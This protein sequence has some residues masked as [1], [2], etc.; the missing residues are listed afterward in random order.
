MGR[1]RLDF[2]EAVAVV[3]ASPLG[4]CSTSSS[5][6]PFQPLAELGKP[7]GS[8]ERV[9][10]MGLAQLTN[11]QCSTYSESGAKVH[12]LETLTALFCKAPAL[13][14]S[15]GDRCILDLPH[16]KCR[17]TGSHARALT[18]DSCRGVQL[19]EATHFSTGALWR[20]RTP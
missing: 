4:S 20:S 14:H 5:A 1:D 10:L 8:G 11:A 19:R 13:R 16:A 12:P 9:E 6:V 3:G 2:E 18:L 15:T 17:P 7:T